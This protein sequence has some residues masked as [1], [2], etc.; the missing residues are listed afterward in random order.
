[1]SYWNEIDQL[2]KFRFN[3]EITMERVLPPH[4]VRNAKFRSKIVAVTRHDVDDVLNVKIQKIL[5]SIDKYQDNGSGFRV[6]EVVKIGMIVITL[7]TA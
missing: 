5:T 3:I 2:I 7:P 1:M 4:E 6:R